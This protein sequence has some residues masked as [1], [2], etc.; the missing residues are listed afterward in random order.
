MS[1]AHK[2]LVWD[3]WTA[4]NAEPQGRH[5]ELYRR[6]VAEDVRWHGPHP[7]NDL[8]GRDAVQEAFWRPFQRALTGLRREPYIL[9]SG[10]F[11]G[12]DW[13]AATGDFVGRFTE[14]WLGVPPSCQT[15]RVRFGEF[16]HLEGG[17]IAESYL[18]LDL[19][20]LMDQTGRSPF[21]FVLADNAPIPGPSTGDG[22]LL[23]EQDAA[24]SAASLELIERMIRGLGA[25]DGRDKASMKQVQ[26]WHPAMRWYGPHGIGTTYGLGG[27]ERNHQLPF[28]HG[29]PDRKGGHHKA[30]FGDGLYAASTGWP[31]VLATHRG[32]YLGVRATGARVGMRVMDFWRREGE[33]L[34]ENWVFIDLPHLFLQMGVDLLGRARG[35]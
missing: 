31:S 23:E 14:S 19:P 8:T 5:A 10:R 7:L 28:L 30:R 17:R 27:F 34:V 6:Y 3:F 12:K 13:V 2:R 26:F 21:A 35:T 16:C 29:F 32:D 22:L 24:A 4:L 15:V 18:L 9:M 11:E 1:A 33:L 25:F 20:S